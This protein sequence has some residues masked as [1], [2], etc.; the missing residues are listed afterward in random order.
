MDTSA[1]SISIKRHK[2][3]YYVCPH[4]ND[5]FVKRGWYRYLTKYIMLKSVPSMYFLKKMY[6]VFSWSD[7]CPQNP[8]NFT[9]KMKENLT[10]LLKNIW[11]FTCFLSRWKKS[12]QKKKSYLWSF[13]K[14]D[15]RNLLPS[16][17]TSRINFLL[18]IHRKYNCRMTLLAFKLLLD[19]SQFLLHKTP[20]E[21]I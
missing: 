8:K 18:I 20:F 15:A 3:I 5:V 14:P 4:K 10:V 7:F 12:Y 9:I 16:G 17:Y 1:C 19:V 6:V 2:H 21:E 11:S 13:N